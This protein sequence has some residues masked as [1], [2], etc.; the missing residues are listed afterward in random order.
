M[1]LTIHCSS[2]FIST[3]MMQCNLCWAIPTWCMTY[4]S[5]LEP[6]T[7]HHTNIEP[8]T[9]YHL[10]ML[11]SILMCPVVDARHRSHC[12]YIWSCS[13]LNFRFM[14]LHATILIVT[15][16]QVM[17]NDFTLSC[18]TWCFNTCCAEAWKVERLRVVQ[19][20]IS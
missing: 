3:D 15:L 9:I 20:E 6:S 5:L 1:V 16:R 11:W 13:W 18:T 17:Y 4:R 8:S 2:D 19:A 14:F 12:S 10:I 7:I